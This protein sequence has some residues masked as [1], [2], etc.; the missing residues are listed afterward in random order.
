[1]KNIKLDKN[2]NEIS[3][4]YNV[5]SSWN[6]EEVCEELNIN[7]NDIE[8]ICVKYDTLNLI[9]KNGEIERYEGQMEDFDFKYYTTLY[10]DENIEDEL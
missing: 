6:L 1:M 8:S 3:V 10:F 7:K 2:V 5:G 4:S 9:M